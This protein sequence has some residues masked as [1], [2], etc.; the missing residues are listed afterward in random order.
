[1]ASSVA[2]FVGASG[3]TKVKGFQGL[4]GQWKGPSCTASAATAGEAGGLE[5]VLSSSED[6]SLSGALSEALW[7]AV[8]GGGEDGDEAVGGALSRMFLSGDQPAGRRLV[9]IWRKEYR[10][11]TVRVNVLFCRGGKSSRVLTKELCSRPLFL[12]VSVCRPLY[13][14]FKNGQKVSVF[15]H[16]VKSVSHQRQFPICTIQVGVWDLKSPRCHIHCRVTVSVLL[17]THTHTDRHV[18]S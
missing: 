7:E 3:W 4:D 2:A 8:A 16:F 9:K 13:R 1:M 18:W 17:H 11:L 15:G 5:A 6:S 12:H 14:T 10:D